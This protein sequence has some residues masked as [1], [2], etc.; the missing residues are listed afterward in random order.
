MQ[1]PGHLQNLP[2]IPVVDC[3][4]LPR[5]EA[6]HAATVALLEQG[7]VKLAG[8][9]AAAD[10]G[11]WKSQFESHTLGAVA[12][13]KYAYRLWPLGEKRHHYILEIH[14]AFNSPAFYGNP[15]VYGAAVAAL[16]GDF[17]LATTAIA[18]AE[19][20]AP[21]QYIHRDQNLLF[22]SSRLNGVLPPVSL[23]VSVPLVATNDVTGGTEF[24]VGSHRQSELPAAARFV[25]T[26]TEPG[27]CL[28]WDSRT[29]HR[30]CANPGD[31]SRPIVLMYYQRPWYFN[32]RNYEVDCEI[33]ITAGNLA[34]VPAMYKPLFD[35]SHRLFTPP[36][37]LAEADGACSCGS[38]LMYSDCHGSA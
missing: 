31:V 24:V 6:L 5:H 27:D 36:Q 22:A 2:Q 8:A 32:F 7:V 30:G 21:E 19:P 28:L 35:W 4:A 18:Y 38:G 26:R 25:R 10:I 17:M 14:Q 20:G 1:L 13:G 33:K 15:F 3:R 16:D 34:R 29:L 37:F 11:N 23:T 9:F 12:R